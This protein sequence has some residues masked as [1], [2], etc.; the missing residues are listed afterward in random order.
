MVNYT[1]DELQK[2]LKDFDDNPLRYENVPIESVYVAIDCI[3]SYILDKR[4]KKPDFKKQY[5]QM[6]ALQNNWD[7]EETH[8]K[9]DDILCEVLRKLGYNRL[10]ELYEKIDK[11]YA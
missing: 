11:W 2:A 3:R 10:V 7:I 6:E 9:A 1:I 5:E 4:M 8:G